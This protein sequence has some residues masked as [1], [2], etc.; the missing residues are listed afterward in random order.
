M[1]LQK[2]EQ[3]THRKLTYNALQ[4]A[5]QIANLQTDESH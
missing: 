3:N 5:I 1:A 2:E 4:K